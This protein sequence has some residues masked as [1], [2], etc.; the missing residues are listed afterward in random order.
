MTHRV[1]APDR[2]ATK[3]GGRYDN[4]MPETTLSPQPRTMNLA[5]EYNFL[6]NFILKG[7]TSLTKRKNQI[8]LLKF[9]LSCTINFSLVVSMTLI[10][11]FNFDFTWI[12]SSL[13]GF[14]RKKT[15]Q[16]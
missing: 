12:L 4:P 13:R 6:L 16:T 1:V 7:A 14:E 15:I 9:K 11:I 5:T 3:V 2:H 8:F 10:L